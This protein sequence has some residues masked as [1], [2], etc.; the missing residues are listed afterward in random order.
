MP[1]AEDLR[2]V[3]SPLGPP[4]VTPQCLEKLFNGEQDGVVLTG[5]L[6]FVPS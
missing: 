2:S 6:H 5:L 4:A 1:D 3:C